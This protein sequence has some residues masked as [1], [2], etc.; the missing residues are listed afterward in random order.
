L[1]KFRKN[2]E[3]PLQMTQLGSKFCSP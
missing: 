3:I 1:T 2:V